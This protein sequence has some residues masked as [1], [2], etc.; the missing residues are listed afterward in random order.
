MATGL[1]L[2]LGLAFVQAASGG[3]PPVSHTADQT[4]STADTTTLTAD[5]A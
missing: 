2:G 4:V 1:G 5:A 3:A